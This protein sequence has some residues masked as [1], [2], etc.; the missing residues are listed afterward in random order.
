MTD[1]RPTGPLRALNNGNRNGSS[2]VARPRIPKPQRTR[3]ECDAELLDFIVEKTLQSFMPL[4][5]V[6]TPRPLH[7]RPKR[8]RPSH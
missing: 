3:A 6:S 4:A 2:I 7:K 8:K 1:P 5:V